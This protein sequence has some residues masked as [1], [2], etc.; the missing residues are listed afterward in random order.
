VGDFA[1][2]DHL[3]L[4]RDFR[5][6]AAFPTDFPF[7]GFAFPPFARTRRRGNLLITS[8]M[9]ALSCSPRPMSMQRA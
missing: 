7:L 5:F 3:F 4:P 6:R 1:Y 9:T 2:A 8:T